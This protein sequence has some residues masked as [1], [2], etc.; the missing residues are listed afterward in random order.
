MH[1]VYSLTLKKSKDN[2]MLIG[3]MPEPNKLKMYWE[4]MCYT[5][6]HFTRLYTNEP[7]IQCKAFK[8]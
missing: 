3:C 4:C 2:G 1:I 5:I 8:Q 7:N 6:N